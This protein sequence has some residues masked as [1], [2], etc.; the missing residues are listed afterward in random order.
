MADRRPGTAGAAKL[1]K[2]SDV[3]EWKVMLDNYDDAVARVA[4]AKK[5]PELVSLDKWLWSEFPLLVKERNPPSCSKQELVRVMQWKLL[6]GKNRPALLNLIQQNSDSSVDSV[7]TEACRLLFSGK[8]PSWKAAVNKLAELRG[9]GPATASAVLAT[10]TPTVPFMADEPLEAVTRRKRDYTLAAYSDLHRGLHA[11]SKDVLHN[12]LS[13]EEAGKA[14]W[15]AAMLSI[16]PAGGGAA[17]ASQSQLQKKRARSGVEEATTVSKL[18]KRPSSPTGLGGAS[19]GAVAGRESMGAADRG[20]A[21]VGAEADT[22]TAASTSS[23][24]GERR[25]KRAKL[26]T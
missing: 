4:T 23:P 6:R 15:A 18:G 3:T 12:E 21:T 19:A 2:S 26:T 22:D 7:S 1:L 16:F 17:A 5:K 9:V 11:L 10:L 14:L 13:P 24:R 8:S 20:L 25:A